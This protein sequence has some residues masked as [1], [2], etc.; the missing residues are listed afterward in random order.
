MKP[1]Y[2]AGR[3]DPHLRFEDLASQPARISIAAYQKHAPFGMLG[4]D[5][6]NAV[7]PARCGENGGSTPGRI[8]HKDRSK[9]CLRAV[10]AWS[11]SAWLSLWQLVE[12]T[13]RKK[14]MSR[15]NLR[16]SRLSR[17]IQA[18][19]DTRVEQGRGRMHASGLCAASAC[20]PEGRTC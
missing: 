7:E 19:S 10:R 9:T 13:P 11:P 2:V 5:G 17:H 15:L 8:E 14:N 3:Y 18:N 6:L 4:C 20:Y 12:E 16:P 1:Q